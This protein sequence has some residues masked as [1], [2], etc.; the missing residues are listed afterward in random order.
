MTAFTVAGIGEILFDVLDDTEELGGAPI[1]FTYHANALGAK[2]YAISTIGND[3]RGKRA[4]AE[5][6]QRRLCTELI[7]VTD[8]YD[9][10]YVLARLDEQGVASYHFP[11]DIAWDHL[12]C[13]RQ[14]VT[15]AQD[16]DGVCF[17]SLAQRSPDSRGEIVR[18]LEQTPEK[19]LKVFDINLRQDFY[20]ESVIT[21][22]LG[23][24]DVVKL[25]DEELPILARMLR[26]AGTERDVLTAL[27]AK[28]NLRLAALTRGAQG[29]LLVAA[30]GYSDHPG[31]PPTRLVDT[32]GAGDSFTAATV[33]G[34]LRGED[35]D[36]INAR[37]NKV[38][39]YVCSQK[40]AMP[41]MP[42]EFLAELGLW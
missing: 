2:G 17:G 35:I 11:D 40:G 14:A 13:N 10:G 12:T 34:L 38:A 22:S 31:V 37:A 23:Y 30:D 41:P 19:T 27:V 32:I 3:S 1:N 39:A 9:T 20:S 8:S 28:Y 36:T 6:R 29:S 24:A 7:T 18:L 26:L 42:P 15:V 4:L 5:L 25:N 21:S 33:I 16:L